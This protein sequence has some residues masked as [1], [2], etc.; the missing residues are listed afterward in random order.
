MAARE[1]WKKTSENKKALSMHFVSNNVKYTYVVV[2]ELK[3][4][5]RHVWSFKS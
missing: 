2:K 1:S 3:P 5:D 4:E